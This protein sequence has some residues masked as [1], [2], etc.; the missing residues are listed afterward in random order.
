MW[1]GLGR[2]L[3]GGLLVY[4][5]CIEYVCQGIKCNGF[6]TGFINCHAQS[7]PDYE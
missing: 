7:L 2:A 1:R 3:E 4:G 6:L 5:P